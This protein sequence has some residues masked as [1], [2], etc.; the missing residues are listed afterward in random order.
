MIGKRTLGALGLSNIMCQ[1]AMC[2]RE[3]RNKPEKEARLE[4]KGAKSKEARGVC[5]K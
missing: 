4:G 2:C 1:C 5:T 3:F